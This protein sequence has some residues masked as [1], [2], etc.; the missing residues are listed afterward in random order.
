MRSLRRSGA[1]R[2]PGVSIAQGVR[3]DAESLANRDLALR[4]RHSN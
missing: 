2:D 3:A 4:P 1:S